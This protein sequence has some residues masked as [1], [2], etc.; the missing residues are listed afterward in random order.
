MIRWVAGV[1]LLLLVALIFDLGLLAYA[2]YVLLAALAV[3]RFLTH[4]WATSL[5]AKRK[6][7]VL[8]AKTGETVSIIM[9]LETL[10]SKHQ[11]NASCEPF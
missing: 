8:K 6:V 10:Q 7:S 2:M 3:S 11:S 9:A 5:T 4:T 1:L